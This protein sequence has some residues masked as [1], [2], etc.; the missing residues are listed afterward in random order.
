MYKEL[1]FQVRGLSSC[2]YITIP[3][4]LNILVHNVC[5]YKKGNIPSGQVKN[6]LHVRESKHVFILGS[7]VNMVTNSLYNIVSMIHSGIR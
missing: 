6:K 4:Y 5:V 1:P 7:S 3:A 2:P